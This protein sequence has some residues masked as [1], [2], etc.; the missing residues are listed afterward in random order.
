MT[1]FMFLLVICLPPFLR[2]GVVNLSVKN[3]DFPYCN[4]AF[5]FLNVNFTFPAYYEFLM[6][7][8]FLIMIS[9]VECGA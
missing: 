8:D 1:L 6:T 2:F 5:I 7:C 9:G 3:Q 4:L